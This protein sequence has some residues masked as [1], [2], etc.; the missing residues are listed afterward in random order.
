[1]GE[2]DMALEYYLNAGRRMLA[3]VLLGALALCVPAHAATVPETGPAAAVARLYHQIE[4]MAKRQNCAQRAEFLEPAVRANYDIPNYLRESLRG[5]WNELAHQD[6]DLLQDQVTHLIATT[7]AA[8][9]NPG[10]RPRIRIAGTHYEDRY[11]RS[12]TVHLDPGSDSVIRRRYLLHRGQDDGRW[13]I[14]N[15]FFERGGSELVHRTRYNERNLRWGGFD[16]L[17]QYF[18]DEAGRFGADC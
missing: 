5:H 9:F 10:D 13:R 3:P 7:Y 16:A 18:R 14:I 2:G 1:M 15:L 8:N 12:V 11:R 17:R 4:Q 6:I